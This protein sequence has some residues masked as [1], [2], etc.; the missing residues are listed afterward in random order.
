M[1]ADRY[2]LAYGGATVSWASWTSKDLGNPALTLSC[3]YFETTGYCGC[4]PAT[5]DELVWL[6]LRPITSVQIIGNPLTQQ[7]LLTASAAG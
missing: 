5:H 6:S 7:G 4:K 3:I 1:F 2:K